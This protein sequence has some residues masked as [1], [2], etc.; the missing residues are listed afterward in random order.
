L[1]RVLKD[2]TPKK[3]AAGKAPKDATPKKVAQEIKEAKNKEP[4]KWP[5]EG[6]MKLLGGLRRP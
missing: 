5:Y 1:S 2:A 6:L 3:T 4:I